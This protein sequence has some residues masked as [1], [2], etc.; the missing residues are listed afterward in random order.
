[1]AEGLVYNFFQ[2]GLLFLVLYI[3]ICIVYRLYLSPLSIFPGPKVAALA[4]WYSNRR[5]QSADDFDMLSGM[6]SIMT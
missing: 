5:E 3:V 2:Y 4:L 1:M 6:S